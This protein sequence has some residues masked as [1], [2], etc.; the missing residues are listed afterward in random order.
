MGRYQ[1]VDLEAG[2]SRKKKSSRPKDKRAKG[3]L[4]EKQDETRPSGK[5][6]RISHLSYRHNETAKGS[7]FILTHHDCSLAYMTR[8]IWHLYLPIRLVLYFVNHQPARILRF[9]TKQEA[10]AHQVS[11]HLSAQQNT[12][13]LPIKNFASYSKM[14]TALT[15]LTTRTK[16]TKK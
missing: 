7:F 15:L 11:C 1:L 16:G 8:N 2:D 13:H 6:I 10:F 9:A 12:K 4:H 14:T 3:K 5:S